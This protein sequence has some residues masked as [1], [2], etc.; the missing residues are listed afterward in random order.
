MYIFSRPPCDLQTDPHFQRLDGLLCTIVNFDALA[1]D[2]TV[3]DAV[4]EKNVR[5]LVD[6]GV[7][8]STLFQ[9]CWVN[10]LPRFR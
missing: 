7:Q 9:V 10:G 3:A 4:R 8:P 6:G 5:V 1:S 2:S